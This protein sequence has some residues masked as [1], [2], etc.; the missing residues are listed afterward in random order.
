MLTNLGK[1]VAMAVLWGAAFLF[2]MHL[3]VLLKGHYYGEALYMLRIVL[4]IPLGTLACAMSLKLFNWLT[5][6]NWLPI[7]WESEYAKAAIICSII[8]GVF[9]LAVQG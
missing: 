2:M 9:W 6:D 3:A 1:G 5:P 4:V 8:G 7:K